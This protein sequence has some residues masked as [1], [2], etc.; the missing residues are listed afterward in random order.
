MEKVDGPEHMDKT[1]NGNSKIYIIGVEQDFLPLRIEKLFT[2]RDRIPGLILVAKRGELI[3]ENNL[4][5]GSHPNPSG[6]LR[7]LKLNY[8]KKIFD[9]YIFFPSPSI[10]YVYKVEQQLKKIIKKDLLFGQK[11]CIFTSVP[12]HALALIGLRLKKKFPEI[13]WITDWCDLWSYDEFYVQKIPRIYRGKLLKIENEILKHCDMN[14]TTNKKAK[15]VLE[16][17]YGVPSEKVISINHSFFRED[18]EESATTRHI[19][20]SNRKNINIGFLGNL[21]KLP[22]VPGP[23]VVKTIEDLIESGVNVELHIFGDESELAKKTVAQSASDGIFLYPATSHKES[24]LNILKCD[25]LLLALSNIPNCDIIMHGKL[26][27]YLLLNRPIIAIVPDRSAV[28][29]MIR[30]TG[31]GYVISY[32]SNWF[33][34]LQ[35]ILKDYL[36]GEKSVFRNDKEIEKY[37]WENIS[38]QWMELFDSVLK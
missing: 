37:S 10:L 27:H 9:R 30:Q 23:K 31:S 32:E 20:R 35:K 3:N 5:L 33:E 13:Q 8:L 16:N 4:V 22:K 1:V 19:D 21:F 18:L 25:F 15:S 36:E 29:D 38:T 12:P 26:P 14:I 28:A 2:L 24:L 11:V 7:I 17:Y 6:L 34:G